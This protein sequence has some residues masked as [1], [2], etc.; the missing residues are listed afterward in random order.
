MGCESFSVGI[1]ANRYENFLRFGSGGVTPPRQP[2]GRRRYW[3][4]A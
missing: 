2:P 4:A 1:L 3:E